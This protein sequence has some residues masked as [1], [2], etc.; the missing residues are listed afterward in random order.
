MGEGPLVAATRTEQ[1]QPRIVAVLS[2]SGGTG[3][4][5][6]AIGLGLALA[7]NR[8]DKTVLVDA[9]AGTPSLGTALAQ[10]LAPTPAEIA[11]DPWGAAALSTPDGLYVVD[12]LPWAAPLDPRDMRDALGV[13]T[14]TY[15]FVLVDVGNDLSAPAQAALDDAD[16]VV[17]VVR[18]GPT[19]RPA[20]LAALDRLATGGPGRLGTVAVAVVGDRSPLPRGA[21]RRA[22]AVPH[23]PGLAGRTGIAAQRLRPATSR[24]YLAL[25][26][27]VAVT[28]PAAKN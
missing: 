28:T 11:R 24:A 17:L 27:R 14:A 22:V 12:G 19:A 20:A 21:S 2:G 18:P 25:A 3:T 26:A 23:D 4:T 13:L 1:A 10:R 7:R 15:T 5:A 16:Q 8:A 6:T 9:H